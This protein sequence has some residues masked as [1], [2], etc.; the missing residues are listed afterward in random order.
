MILGFKTKINEKPTFFVEKILIGID[1]KIGTIFTETYLNDYKKRVDQSLPPV[2]YNSKLH[3]IREDKNNRWKSGVMIDFFINVRTKKMF[4]F[5]PKLRVVSTQ[6]IEIK[7]I[8]MTIPKGELRPWVKVDGK[9]VF[10]I[11]KIENDK[12]LQIAQNDGF[13]TTE[14][15][16]SYFN[17]DFN[18]KIIHWTDLKY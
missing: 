12:M 7:Y 6:K 4:R 8:P 13:D 1:K 2:N 9:T 5:A 18:G 16:F 17:E 10:F 11:D 15:F 14:D 3:T